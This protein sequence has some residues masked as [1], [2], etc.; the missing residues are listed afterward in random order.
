MRFATCRGRAL[1]ARRGMIASEILKHAF[2]AQTMISNLGQLPFDSTFGRLELE[3]LWGPA[4]LRGV[5]GEQ[6]L[7]AITVNGALHLVHTSYV[8]IEGLLQGIEEALR[9]STEGNIST[10]R[11]WS[12]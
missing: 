11:V 6:T 2:V 10:R 5:D 12:G 7:G 3:A 1:I 4:A 8:P 9:R